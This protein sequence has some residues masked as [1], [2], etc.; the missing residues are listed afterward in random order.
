M[1]PSRKSKA[2]GLFSGGLD[3]I[4][5]AKLLSEQGV[6]VVALH[7]KSP[8]AVPGRVESDEKLG[9]LAELAGANLVSVDIGDEYLQV[10]S[11]P[12]HGYARQFAPCVDCILYMLARARE[13]AREIKADF[14]FTG[15]VVG[16]RAVC[17]NKRALKEIEVASGMQGRLLRPLSAKL[18]EPTIPE[19][20]GLVRRERLLDI[21]GRNRR[22]QIRLAHEFGFLDYPIPG[23]GCM[24]LDKNYAARTREA[25]AKGQ[26]DPAEL[27]LLRHGRHFR[28]ESGAKVVVGRNEQENRQLEGAAGQA[29]VVLRPVDVMG[30]ITILRAKKVTKKDTELA[31]RIAARYSDGQAGKSVK[32]AAADREFAV[33]PFKD[34]EIAGWRVR[35]AESLPAPAKPA[36]PDPE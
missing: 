31:A 25:V 34:D 32:F 3:S 15:E 8:F 6:G 10:V 12:E 28:L 30:P 23:T 9:R 35:P 22:R 16:Q 1:I 5:A 4:L 20:T 18:L 11:Q 26:L 24:L 27:A 19:L 36:T 17:Q 14:V 13:L 7:L 33:K 29:D 21:K 2:V